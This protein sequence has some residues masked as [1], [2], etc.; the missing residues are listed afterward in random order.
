MDANADEIVPQ[1]SAS[2]GKNADPAPQERRNYPGSHPVLGWL[3][4]GE[5]EWDIADVGCF[6]LIGMES[7]GV[8]E[9]CLLFLKER[10]PL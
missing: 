1:V 9:C 8:C 7:E 4:G 3:Y 5:S 6:Q 2:L 10:A